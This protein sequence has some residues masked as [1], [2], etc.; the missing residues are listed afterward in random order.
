[1][2]LDVKVEDIQIRE[3]SFDF[4]LKSPDMERVNYAKNN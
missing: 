2:G 3:N 4:V 1:M